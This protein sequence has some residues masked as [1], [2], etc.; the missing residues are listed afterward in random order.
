MARTI[1][2]VDD[3]AV[4][5]ETLTYNL[6]QEGYQV[7]TAVDGIRA[8]EVVQQTRP[9]LIILDVLLPNMDGLEVC[10]KLRRESQSATIPILMLTAKS[11]KMDEVIGLEVGAD[12]YVTK[13]F[14]RRELLARV[15]ALLRRSEYAALQDARPREEEA[16]QTQRPQE[17]VAG[18]LRI[19]LGGRRVKCRGQQVELQPKQ[20][21]L[22]VYLVRKR[23][24]VVTRDS[25]LQ[26]VWGYDYA[27]DTR[28]DRYII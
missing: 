23:G 18:P 3:E 27:G 16:P 24:T 8:L 19:D 4:L 14:G 21:D 17:L 9:D 11:D 26:D 15:R 10:S 20:F 1:L 7:I 22:L 2:I 12:D 28:L 5:V 13:P 25:L 6:E